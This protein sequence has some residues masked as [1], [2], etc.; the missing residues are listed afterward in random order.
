[1]TADYLSTPSEQILETFWDKL[2][3]TKWGSYIT[4]IERCAIL[5]AKDLV[6]SEVVHTALDV[7]CGGGRWSKLLSDFGWNLVCTDI[8]SWELE[9]CQKR[10]PE[11]DCI[12]VEKGA[13]CI[14]CET[15]TISLILCIEVFSVVRSEWFIHEVSRVLCPNGVIVGIFANKWSLWGFYRHFVDTITNS[16][17][18]YRAVYPRWKTKFCKQG[19][20]IVYEEGFCWF[21]FSRS[22]NSALIPLAIRLENYLCLYRL[23]NVS[24]WVA[25]VAR[26]ATN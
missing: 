3:R 1:M 15:S 13:Q 24:P 23:P 26:K 12:L 20:K 4:G 17:D 5:K 14:P 16:D 2:S 18:Y 11:A 9:I 19:F 21:P 6:E 10:I 8:C 7:G 22:S 25:F